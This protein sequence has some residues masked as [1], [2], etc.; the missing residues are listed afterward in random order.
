MRDISDIQAVRSGTNLLSEFD[1]VFLKDSEI[2][3]IPIRSA[4]GVKFD[5]ADVAIKLLMRDQR[6]GRPPDDRL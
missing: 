5:Q 6:A 3:K 1:R 4:E 2:P